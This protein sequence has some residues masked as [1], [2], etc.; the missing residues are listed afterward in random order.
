VIISPRPAS[1]PN[2]VPAVGEPTLLAEPTGRAGGGRRRA[3]GSGR[4]RRG[5]PQ[6]RDWLLHRSR[7]AGARQ[8]HDEPGGTSGV[9]AAKQFM[10]AK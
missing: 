5:S 2:P 7:L 4:Q 10:G 1:R 6:R 3:G 9:R 8:R